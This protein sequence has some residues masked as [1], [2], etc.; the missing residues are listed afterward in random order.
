MSEFDPDAFSRAWNAHNIDLIMAMSTEDCEFHASSGADP[1]GAISTGQDAVR[2][3]Y[4]AIF[5]TFPD[6]QWSNSRSTQIGENRFLTEWRF[7]AT[8]ADGTRLIVDGLDLLNISDGKV[9]VKNSYRKA[10]TN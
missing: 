6:A 3:A 8:K 7:I 1:R 2:A 4:L 9:R 10:I 5:K